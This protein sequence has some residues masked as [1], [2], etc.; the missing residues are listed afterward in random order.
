IFSAS[1][2]WNYHNQA[3]PALIAEK[4][5]FSFRGVIKPASSMGDMG[6]ALAG[7]PLFAE[8]WAEK[9]CYYV[10]SSPCLSSDPEFP[11]VV[12]GVRPG[13][14]GIASGKPSVE[15]AGERALVCA[16]HDARGRNTDGCDERRRG[17]R[18]AP[19]SPVRGAEQPP[20]V[21]RRLRAKPSVETAATGDDPVD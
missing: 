18:L 13:A 14:S 20:R 11:R 10:N 16:D 2:S 7:H 12:S 19:R 17:R 8:A 6:D 15:R 21:H 5:L 9:L 1:Y 4:G 3:D